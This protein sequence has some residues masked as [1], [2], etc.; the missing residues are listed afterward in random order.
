AVLAGTDELTVHENGV[1]A[2]N[3]PY[4]R[5]QL[6]AQMTRATDPLVLA[7][8]SAWL[9]TYVGRPV[10]IVGSSLG[11]TKAQ[12]CG[13]LTQAGLEHMVGRTFSWDG[14]QRVAGRPQCGTCTS[15]LLRRQAIHAAG[16]AQHDRVDRYRFDVTD[17]NHRPWSALIGAFPSLWELE[18]RADDWRA[19][20]GPGT[21]SATLVDMYR[22]CVAE[23]T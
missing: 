5:A 12:S 22:A 10:R 3:L 6:G 23:W 15:C 9:T 8:A 11:R 18:S 17:P 19:V 2:L 16:L 1:G 13:A 4:N 7:E 14:F 21:S 20:G